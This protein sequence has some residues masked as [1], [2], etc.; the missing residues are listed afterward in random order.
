MQ[1][2]KTINGEQVMVKAIELADGTLRIVDASVQT[3]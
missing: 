2:S 3:Q 1:F